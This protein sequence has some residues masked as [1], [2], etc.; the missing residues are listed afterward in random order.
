MVLQ[1]VR[2][3]IIKNLS[4]K[5][6]YGSMIRLLIGINRYSE[7][8]Y[9][10][11]ILKD[12]HQLEL[13]LS[14]KVIK[15]LQLRIALIDFLKRDRDMYQMIALNFSMHREIAELLET[16]A[17]ESLKKIKINATTQL[18]SNSRSQLEDIMQELIDAS[19]SYS[20]A[21]CFTRSDACAKLAQLIALQI[22][23]LST[24]FLV[25]INLSETQANH[26]INTHNKFFESHIVAD[27]YS[28]H[29]NWCIPLF[30]NI[31]LNGDWQY[32][33]D[34]TTYYKLSTANF[35]EIM[36]LYSKFK[37][38]REKTLPADKEKMNSVKQHIQKLVMIIN[39]L[40]LMY[41]YSMEHNLISVSASLVD[42][43]NVGYLRDLKRQNKI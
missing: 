25:I 7:M 21:D 8:T 34:Y 33:R 38:E 15:N 43:Q 37:K 16:Q 41:K 10:F 35:E 19:E 26:F 13:L 3:L 14:K 9:I 31:I 22:N 18:T 4:L 32:Y 11:D 5:Q 20:R 29:H 30:N 36:G 2:V 28:L 17:K 40:K 24:S 23:Y 39:D 27:A 1:K 6:D 42:C 12:N